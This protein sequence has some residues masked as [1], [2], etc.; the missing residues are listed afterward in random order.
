MATAIISGDHVCDVFREKRNKIVICTDKRLNDK[1]MS[2]IQ[3]VAYIMA[4]AD[5]DLNDICASITNR[6]V[7]PVIQEGYVAAG[8]DHKTKARAWCG[9]C[10]STIRIGESKG[11]HHDQFCSRCGSKIDWTE[12]DQSRKEP[13]K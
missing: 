11:I 4:A 1:Q 12:F 8:M 2:G 9:N 6:P 7:K 3:M 10:Q 5:A 13:A